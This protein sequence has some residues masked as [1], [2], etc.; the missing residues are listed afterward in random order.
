GPETSPRQRPT[1]QVIGQVS[2]HHMDCDD[3]RPQHEIVGSGDEQKEVQG[4][5][6]DDIDERH[7]PHAMRQEPYERQ[8]KGKPREPLADEFD[9]LAFLGN[10]RRIIGGVVDGVDLHPDCNSRGGVLKLSLHRLAKGALGGRDCI[11]LPGIWFDCLAQRSGKR[12]ETGFGNMMV[13]VAVQG[14]DVCRYACI[15]YEGLKPLANELGIVVADLWRAERYPP[16]EIGSSGYVDRRAR[17]RIVHRQQRARVPPDPGLVGEGLAKR[18]AD[19]DPRVLSR[20]MHVDM[21]VTLRPDI[22]VDQRMARQ[23]LEH[24]VEKADPGL[25]LVSAGAVEIY[26]NR[27]FGFARLAFNGSRSHDFRSVTP[28]SISGDAAHS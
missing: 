20:M 7:Q 9:P 18:L 2:N 26:G 8:Q 13:V 5:H 28:R 6:A 17:Q 1:S 10:R 11:L 12:L 3:H 16:Y 21:E 22:Q 14:L 4:H 23:L 25:H 15:V 27:Y 24:V 19:G